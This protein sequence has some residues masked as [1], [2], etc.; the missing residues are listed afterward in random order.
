MN[1]RLMGSIKNMELS[2]WNRWKIFYSSLYFQFYNL[3][4]SKDKL[5][6]DWTSVTLQVSIDILC[7]IHELILD[8]T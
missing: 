7:L 5:N 8:L 4:I 6:Q 3:I 1:R 2:F